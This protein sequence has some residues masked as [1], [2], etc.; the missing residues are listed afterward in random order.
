MEVL[1][2]CG[3][4][5]TRI[6]GV[7]DDLPK[8]M[9]E[10]GERPIVWHV[11]KTYARHGFEDFVLLLGYRGEAVKDYFVNYRTM[12]ADVAV[13]LGSGGGV[14]HLGPGGEEKWHVVLA[15]TGRDAM[16]GARI[17]RGARYVKGKS[18][19]ATYGDGVAD[20]DVAKL[21]AFH[22]SHGKLATVTAVRPPGRFGAL[23]LEGDRV[24]A[25]TEKPQ[26]T[27]GFI[28]GGFFVFEKAFVDRYL[29]DDESLVLEREPLSRAA[30]D[31]E[32]MVY[33]H[34]GFWQ[35]MDTYRDW[36]ALNELWKSGK[37][38]WR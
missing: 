17:F 8:P 31:G 18:F 25:F 22:R 26:T 38:P 23:E 33:R 34:E 30:A 12:N 20:V 11:M 5:G 14:E 36:V 3:G 1:V 9:I 28:N 16:T 10:I 6:R 27:E 13:R 35:P 32:L 4:Q 15:G 7:A 29:S 21:V 19:L 24:R 37:A 2:L